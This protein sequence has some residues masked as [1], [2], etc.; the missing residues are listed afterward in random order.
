M[1]LLKEKKVDLERNVYGILADWLQEKTDFLNL[2]G[3][4]IISQNYCIRLREILKI[5]L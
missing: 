5:L 4:F 3:H 1:A 2:I